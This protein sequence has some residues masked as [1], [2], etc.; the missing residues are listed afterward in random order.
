MLVG[1]DR[2]APA[3]KIIKEGQLDKIHGVGFM[4]K[5]L[6]HTLF[7]KLPPHAFHI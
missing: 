5:I 3:T 2:A 4:F 6:H 7:I 1:T